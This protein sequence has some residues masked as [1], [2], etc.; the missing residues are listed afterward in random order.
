[1]GIRLRIKLV[2]R[3]AIERLVAALEPKTWP[4]DPPGAPPIVRSQVDPSRIRP[5]N[6]DPIP[7]RATKDLDE[8]AK[9]RRPVPINPWAGSTKVDFDPRPGE[10][11][12]DWAE[13]VT[14]QRRRGGESV[15]QWIGRLLADG[16][17][18]PEPT[19]DERTLCE[20]GH[21]RLHHGNRLST[22]DGSCFNC[23]CRGFV[24]AKP[25]VFQEISVGEKDRSTSRTQLPSPRARTDL[26]SAQS[27]VG[28]RTSRMREHVAA[29]KDLTKD[30][31]VVPGPG[32][33]SVKVGNLVDQFLFAS[34]E[35]DGTMPGVLGNPRCRV[36]YRAFSRQESPYTQAFI[37]VGGIRAG[38]RLAWDAGSIPEDA[39]KLSANFGTPENPNPTID[40]V[41]AGVVA[42]LGILGCL[43]PG[44]EPAPVAGE[45]LDLSDFNPFNLIIPE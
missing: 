10:S 35:D 7:P 6:E 32:R 44:L 5:E 37:A 23:A 12:E 29:W 26:P 41:A 1:M 14:R 38:F 20:C 13:R 24:E 9:S 16:W 30:R 27:P 39:E 40:D 28:D 34:N 3:L 15:E 2:A 45:P 33:V 17:V 4:V 36:L 19:D 25:A 42:L 8:W 31:G 22:F 18:P 43:H 21:A 11:N